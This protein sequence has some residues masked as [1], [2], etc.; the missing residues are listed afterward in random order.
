MAHEM[1]RRRQ[2]VGHKRPWRRHRHTRPT[3][4]TIKHATRGPPNGPSGKEIGHNGPGARRLV[5]TRRC[6]RKARPSTPHM[7]HEMGRRRKIV[8]HNSPGARRGPANGEVGVGKGLASTQ[9]SE[10]ERGNTT[11]AWHALVPTV[12][13]AIGDAYGAGVPST[14]WVWHDN[15]RFLLCPDVYRQHGMSLHR[16]PPSNGDLNPIE[17]VWAWLRRDLAHREQADLKANRSLT[18]QQFNKRCA[19][20]LNTYAAVKDGERYSPLQKLIRGMPKRLR[21][22]KANLYGRCGK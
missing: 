4:R 5:A 6:R 17:T 3:E 22:C 8:G 21:E 7:A 20:L 1:G 11:E 19:Q 14:P 18:K 9:P 15:E 16:F 2:K 12:R 13:A 10:W